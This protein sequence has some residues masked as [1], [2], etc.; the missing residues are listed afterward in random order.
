[1]SKCPV[2]DIRINLKGGGGPLYK[3]Y[4]YVPPQ[5]VGFLRLFGLKTCIEF[6]HYGL[7]LGIGKFL[8]KS[9]C[10]F[11]GKMQQD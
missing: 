10:I 4:R 8:T 7:K 9:R 6:D 3:L 5:R 2:L 1:M 11:C